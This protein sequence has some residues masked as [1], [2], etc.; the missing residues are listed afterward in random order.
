MMSFAT[1]ATGMAGVA[2]LFVLLLAGVPIGASLGLVGVAGLAIVLG[3]L[4]PALIK[5]S[6]TL[7]PVVASA[8]R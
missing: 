7:L 4:E 2:I 3:G 8:S 1:P 6:V 5:S